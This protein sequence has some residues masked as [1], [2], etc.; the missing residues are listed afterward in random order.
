MIF[1]TYL[2]VMLPSFFILDKAWIFSMPNTNLTLHD[3]IA[4]FIIWWLI[5]VVL[6]NEN[7]DD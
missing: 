1:K 3:F 5:A 2:F 4:Y 7:N 6:D